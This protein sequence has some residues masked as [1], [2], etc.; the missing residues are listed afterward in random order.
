MR[1]PWNCYVIRANEN[2]L[3]KVYLNIEVNFKRPKGRRRQ[4]WLHTLDS[5]FEASQLNPDQAYNWAK[6]DQGKLTPLLNGTNVE[7]EESS[8]LGLYKSVG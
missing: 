7:E 5:N 6:W 2:S 3:V 8:T 1:L 4:R